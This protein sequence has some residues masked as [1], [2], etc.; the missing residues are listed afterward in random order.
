M[1]YH[2][3]DGRCGYVLRVYKSDGVIM[4]GSM[5]DNVF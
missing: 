1:K 5:A 3:L 4:A 2:V